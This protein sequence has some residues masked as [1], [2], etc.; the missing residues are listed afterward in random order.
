MDGFLRRLATHD[1]VPTIVELQ[2]HVEDIRRAE[3]EKCLRR[4][5]PMTT[6]QQQAID[7]LTT[8]IINKI[9]H[10][11]ILRIKE[12]AVDRRDEIES[13]RDTIRR[14]FGLR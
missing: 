11:P 12:T 3:L 8:S 6:E 10:Y 13:M 1:A 14:I 2:Q 9:L 5:G 7:Q 4:M